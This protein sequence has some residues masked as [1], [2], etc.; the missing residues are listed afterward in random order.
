MAAISFGYTTGGSGTLSLSDT[1]NRAYVFPYVNDT[2]VDVYV[3]TIR[4]KGISTSSGSNQWTVGIY[5]GDEVGPQSLLVTSAVQTGMTPGDIDVA[6]PD[7]I[8]IPAGEIAWLGLNAN[9][10][11]SFSYGGSSSFRVF[12]VRLMGS[13]VLLPSQFMTEFTVLGMMPA[14]FL[15]D[16]VGPG[17]P[18]NIRSNYDFAEDLT[19]GYSNVRSPYAFSQPLTEGYSAIRASYGFSQPLTEGYS[20]VRVCYAFCQ[21]L[22]PV[23]PE[24]YMS[25]IPFPGFGNSTANPS[26]PAGADPFNSALPGLS[27]SVHKK[28]NFRTRISS[29]ASGNE[30]RNTLM[31]YPIWDFEL[32]YE[33]LEDRSGANSSLKTLLGFFLSRQGSFD[34]WLFKDPDDYLCDNHYCG[35]ADGVNLEFPFSRV[36]G[37]F[38]ERV[39]QVDTANAVSVFLSV[40]ENGTIPA[41]PGPYT[42]T[43]A[44]A[45][46][47]VE[48]LGVTK[49]GVPMTPV[50]SA[51]AAG[52][53]SVAAGVYTFNAAD[54]D[55]A[56][57][58][59]YRYLIDPADYTVTMP[60]RLIFDSAPPTGQVSWS[61]QFFF[62]CRFAE[63][64]QDY[65]KFY[66]KLWNLQECSFRSII[67]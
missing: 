61:G 1:N 27:F 6:L 24:E 66:D 41:T 22:F 31:Q 9:S 43:V 19:E 13:S 36:M 63:D 58:I 4:L 25:E 23:G 7:I 26:I 50:A 56:V 8:S 21:A 62:V 42:I 5:S 10:S 34:S 12:G 47:F 53:Y 20:N 3:D 28:P 57:V 2:G 51:P 16:T 17:D 29:A 49:G 37:G 33:F 60:N 14:Q 11:V 32:T 55:D 45:A 67:A 39:G 40:E 38:R 18:T 35:E 15:G 30:V 48:D 44:Q 46:A 59:S 54:E 65:E 64:Q 52:Q